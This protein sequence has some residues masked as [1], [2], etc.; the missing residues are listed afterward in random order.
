MTKNTASE[1]EQ[2]QWKERG[3]IIVG[4]GV[5]K[6]IQTNICILRHITNFVQHN[7]I[8]CPAHFTPI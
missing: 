4:F 2:A 7:Y 3:K 8:I 6:H 1:H 5:L